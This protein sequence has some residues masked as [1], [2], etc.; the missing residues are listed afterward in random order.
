[1]I[2]LLLYPWRDEYS[3]LNVF[4]YI[5][6]RTIYASITALVVCLVM[7]PWLIRRLTRKR[8]GETIRDDGPASHQSKAGTPTMGGTLIVFAL[9]AS[10]LLWGDLASSYVWLVIGVTLAL[11]AVGFVDDSR[12]VRGMK[13]GLPGRRKLQLQTAIAFV[14][15]LLL[16]LVTDRDT[17]L[18][19]PFL[20]HVKVEL[21]WWYLPFAVFVIVAAS[22]AVNLTDGLDGLAIGPTII[23]GAL[24]GTFAYVAGNSKFAGYLQIPYLPGTG[25]LA[26]YCGALIGAGLG[27]LWYNTYPAQV[28]MGDTGSLALGG[29]LGFLAV[30]TK[31]ELIFLLAGGIF[32]IEALSVVIQVTSFK[33]TRKRVFKMAPIHHHFEVKGW[34]EQK[35]VVRF[36][37]VSLILALMA[38][39]TL[40]LR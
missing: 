20:K 6:F 1:M 31:N 16:L 10:T 40:K 14:A 27:F 11:A 22:N 26:V 3:V 34:H 38:L 39:S 8:V 12:K 35:V 33:L 15:V 5:T 7:G 25:E 21:G 29:V 19:V 36:W 17:T 2:Y 4:R 18:A 28:F 13:K 32:V 24:Y 37:I 30:S 9:V 23:V